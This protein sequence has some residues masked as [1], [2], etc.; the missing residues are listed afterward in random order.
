MKMKPIILLVLLFRAT[1]GISSE[2]VNQAPVDDLARL[3]DTSSCAGNFQ[4]GKMVC[5]IILP[6]S[7][8]AKRIKSGDHIIL[9][10]NL[11]TSLAETPITTLDASIVEVQS[12]V[13]GGSVLRIRIDK[14]VGKDGR[15]IPVEAR[16][17]AVV[18]QSSV[19][20]GWQFPAIIADRFPRTPEDD[21]RLPGEKK[22]SDDQAHTSSLD[23]MPDI[24]VHYKVVCLDKKKKVSANP[25]TNLLDARGV[26]GYKK[27]TLEPADPVSPTESVLTS[28]K[29]IQF[30]AGTV[31]VLEVKY[32]PLSF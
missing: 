7:V 23:S 12:G 19:S 14:A 31:L 25:C 21:E 30:T 11:I 13:N 26:Y 10:T 28:K 3:L 6:H 5:E 20:E 27:V 8:D 32:I 16:I 22:L 29:N 17:V 24:P 9:R 2:Q 4:S 15:E 18:S 1:P